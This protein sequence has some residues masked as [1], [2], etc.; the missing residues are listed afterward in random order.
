MET[1]IKYESLQSANIR[2]SNAAD[3][4]RIMDISSNVNINNGTTVS[5]IDNG[6]VMQEGIIKATFNSWNEG[7]LNISYQGVNTSEEQCAILNAVNEFI[8]EVKQ[9]I[10]E[11]PIGTI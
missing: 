4:V 3:S 2:V 8:L 7:M 11:N 10:T 5:N 1:K 6:Q 9:Y